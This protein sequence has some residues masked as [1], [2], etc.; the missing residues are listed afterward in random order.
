V[1]MDLV[2]D[3]GGETEEGGEDMKNIVVME[4]H[5]SGPINYGSHYKE[6]A[7]FYCQGGEY[8]AKTLQR[9][10]ADNLIQSRVVSQAE[11]DALPNEHPLNQIVEG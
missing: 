2:A 6:D 5:R 1:A 11:W 8:E 10:L 9:W 4:Y 3:C 7:S